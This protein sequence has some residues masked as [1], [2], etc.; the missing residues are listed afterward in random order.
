M[1][2]GLGTWVLVKI[3]HADHYFVLKFKLDER[4]YVERVDFSLPH[5]WLYYY[6][7]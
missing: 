1:G 6:D 7:I 3:M 4:K 5:S 2:L